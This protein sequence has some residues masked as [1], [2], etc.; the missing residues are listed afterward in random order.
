MAVVIP[1]P[2]RPEPPAED[3]DLLS[4]VDFA[5]R[6][7]HDILKN[8]GKDSARKQAEDCRLMLQAAFDSAIRQD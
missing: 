2:V 1:F 4:A 7:L 3:I 5:V 6:D 8:W